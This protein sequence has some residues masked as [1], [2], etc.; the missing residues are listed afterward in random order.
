M[1]IEYST[2][3]VRPPLRP[4]ETAR[5]PTGRFFFNFTLGISSYLLHILYMNTYLYLCNWGGR[6]FSKVRNETHVWTLATLHAV[7]YITLY[8]RNTRNEKY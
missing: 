5:L 1:L 7:G 2:H 8:E 3:D 6:G 4:H